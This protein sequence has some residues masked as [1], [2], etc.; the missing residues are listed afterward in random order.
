ML[1]RWLGCGLIGIGLMP[2][3]ANGQ[4]TPSEH[5]EGHIR[6]GARQTYFRMNFVSSDAGTL[7]I[8]GQQVPFEVISRAGARMEVR[9]KEDKPAIFR[10]ERQ[11]NHVAGKVVVNGS[12]AGQ[13]QMDLEP[14]LPPARNREEAWKQDLAYASRK[15]PKLDHSFTPESSE[16]FRRQLAWMEARVRAL[17]DQHLMTGLAKAVALA[18]N[19]HT[20]LYL[21]RNRTAVRQYPI[22]VWWFRN[23]LHVIR[24]TSEHADLLGCEVLKISTHSAAEARE[25]VAPL[26]SGSKTWADYMSSYTLT[27]PE[28]LHGLDLIPDMARARWTF[29][30]PNGTRSLDLAPLPL[31][32]SDRTVEAWPNL[33]PRS[34]EAEKGLVGLQFD[35]VPLYLRHLERNYWFEFQPDSGLLYF[36]FNRC[37]DHADESVHDFGGRL[38]LAWRDPKVRTFVVDLRFNTGGNLDLAKDLMERL[39]RAT[40]DRPVYVI[41]GRA[42]FSAGLYHAAQWKQWGKA[43]FIGEPAG[44]RLDFW[45]EG[46]NVILPNSGLAIHFADAFHSYS[47]KEYP[48]RKPYFEDLSID[49]LAPDYPVSPTFEDYVTGRDSAM[50]VVLRGHTKRAHSGDGHHSESQKHPQNT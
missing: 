20:R 36:Q 40:G 48:D 44:D 50:D 24:A 41:I 30:C 1:L 38:E 15:L 22:R 28:I 11:A 9:T 16:R 49:S 42:T 17:D 31:N 4:A 10:G 33:A 13:F 46:G 37:A 34:F 45:S 5:W 32:K 27:S 26:Y 35:S 14:L 25:R 29:R 12:E 39:Q 3:S 6:E 7:E 21:V 19:A 2:F 47:R 8:L 23:K 43:T 18:D